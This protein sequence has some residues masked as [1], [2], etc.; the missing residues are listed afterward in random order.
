MRARS[1]VLTVAITAAA[2]V[3]AVVAVAQNDDSSDDGA[4]PTTTS[5]P[6]PTSTTR[7]AS[8]TTGLPVEG[9]GRFT[10][11]GG[12]I[13]GP[14]GK[15]FIPMGANVA[16]R[17]GRYETGYAFNWNGT[18]TDHV[19]DVIAWGWNTVRATLVCTP[20]GEPT[21]DELNAGIDAF[22]EEYTSKGIVVMVECHDITGKNYQETDKEVQA[23]YPFWDRLASKWADNPYVWFN[24][25]NE[26]QGT[27][28]PAGVNNWL[29]LQQKALLRLRAVAPTSI[30]VA[31]IPGSGQGVETFVGPDSIL[32]LGS[33]QCNVLYGWHSYGAVGKDGQFGDVADYDNK[34]TSTANHREVL[35]YIDENAIPVVIGEFGDPLTL[36]EGNAG[37]PIWNR[38]G[39]R[40]V[41]EYAP[42]HGVGLLWW[43][44]TGD[45]GIFLTYSLMQERNSA[46]WSAATTGEGLSDGGKRFWDASKNQPEP[47]A[48]TGDLAASN[49]P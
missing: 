24:Y 44:G 5:A 17:Q 9:N 16:V 23:L 28:T 6:G 18:A 13:V 2:A 15:T 1:W 20:D 37:Q 14:D 19:D 39:A 36:D 47:V 43:H 26:P 45:S 7:P 40:A 4:G 41:I 30:F 22:I 33:G 46:P 49:C 25:F 42:Q 35:E 27:A 38:I 21:F 32:R 10:I 8:T 12:D 3:V 48:F 29:D 31:D 11:V 34:A